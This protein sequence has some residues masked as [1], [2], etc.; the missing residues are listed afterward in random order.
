M[1]VYKVDHQLRKWSIL[2]LLRI[3]RYTIRGTLRK[4]ERGLGWTQK[5][6]QSFTL[7]LSNLLLCKREHSHHHG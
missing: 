4:G 2:F 7:L 5:K 1:H 3:Q 6:I